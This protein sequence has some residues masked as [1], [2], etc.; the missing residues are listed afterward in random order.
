MPVVGGPESEDGPSWEA[1]SAEGLLFEDVGPAASVESVWLG[2]VW[3]EGVAVAEGAPATAVSLSSLSESP[4]S[5]SDFD[6]GLLP[7][8][9][10]ESAG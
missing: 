3:S 7:G 8:D 10:S 9:A 4:S 5:S 1:L 2:S 6:V